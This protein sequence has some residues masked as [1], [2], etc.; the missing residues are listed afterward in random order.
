[1]R[2]P[3]QHYTDLPLKKPRSVKA[4]REFL[5]GHFRYDTMS[6]HNL[7]RS[8]AVCVKL[9]HLRMTS[10]Q[11]SRCYELLSSEDCYDASGVNLLMLEFAEENN[12]QWQA[13]FNGRSGG[14]IVLYSGG[15]RDDGYKSRC[16]KCC[17]LNA[18][19]A[20]PENNK[21]GRCGAI[22]SR[23]NLKLPHLVPYTNGASVD[24][25]GTAEMEDHEVRSRFATVWAFD[26]MVE[27]AVASF[28][29]T[30]MESEV[31]EETVMVPH[32]VNVIRERTTEG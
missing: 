17:Q 28:V 15:R 30:A 25:N 19:V 18:T 10:E 2:K 7:C 27:E 13:G 26:T 23:I 12:W 21:C 9:N 8:Y 20:T 24:S 29:M 22:D 14:Y 31:V 4:M 16:R 5:D 3:R 6:S 11:L 1:M 32:K